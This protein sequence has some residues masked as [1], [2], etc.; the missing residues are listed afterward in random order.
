MPQ[1]GKFGRLNLKKKLKKIKKMTLNND[2][3]FM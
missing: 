2:S 1:T 3:L